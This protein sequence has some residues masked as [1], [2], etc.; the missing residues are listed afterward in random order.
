MRR[1][2]IFLIAACVLSTGVYAEKHHKKPKTRAQPA[3]SY[4]ERA[5]ALAWADALAA[6]H[7]LD[8]RWVR[9]AVGAARRQTR[10]EQLVLPAASAQA[11]NWQ[12]YHARFVEPVRVRAGLAFWQQ[13]AALLARAEAEYGVP[14]H[15]IVG[16]LGVETL[17]GRDMGSWRVLDALAT[18]AF[19]FPAAHPRADARRAFFADELAQ[20]LLLAQASGADPAHARG[21]YAGAMGMPQFMPSSWQR[22]AVDFDGDARVDLW[23]STADAIGSVA[24]YFR[25]HGWT[26]GLPT[27]YPV[28]LDAA[29]LELAALLAPDIRPSFS[30][31]EMA[32]HG[33]RV[34]VEDEGE[35]YAGPL[36]LIE[37]HNGPAAAP[38][39]VAGTQNFYVV[40][41]YNW[42]SYYALAVIALGEA[43]AA[44]RHPQREPGGLAR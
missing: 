9:A 14:A 8:A 28:H 33:A 32:Q 6:R 3:A 41:R 13:H 15:L 22:W 29:R 7:G 39:Y 30:V 19:D 36:A 11:K 42:S 35:A 2:L 10:I 38:S 27:H 43:V 31:S 5:D 4:A 23:S 25:A 40:T 17:Y 21:S 44:A 12:A 1:K 18:L 37:L 16:I 24:N 34:E 20:F 26:P